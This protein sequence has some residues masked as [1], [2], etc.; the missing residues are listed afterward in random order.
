MLSRTDCTA[1]AL[2]ATELVPLD[3]AMSE[4]APKVSGPLM[5]ICK[6]SLSVVANEIL[7]Y[8]PSGPSQ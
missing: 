2:L 7:G 1:H 6:M 5:A 3:D 4:V 8:G